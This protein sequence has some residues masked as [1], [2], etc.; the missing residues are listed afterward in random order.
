L[1]DTPAYRVNEY[2]LFRSNPM[3]FSNLYVFSWKSVLKN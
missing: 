3:L 2:R 1:Q